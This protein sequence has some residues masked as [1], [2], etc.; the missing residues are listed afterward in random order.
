M[1]HTRVCRNNRAYIV[2]TAA[3]LS[4]ACSESYRSTVV[5]NP[6][7][8]VEAALVVSDSAPAV[9][10]TLVVS[11]QAIA[12]QGT[13]GSYTARINFDPAALQFDGEVP[14]TDKAIRA[15]N[16]LPGLVRIAGAAAA[17]FADG[18]LA[19]YRFVVLR[20]NSVRTL[21][22]V[23][24]EIHMISRVDAKTTLTIAPNRVTS[25]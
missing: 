9:G 7:P 6:V 4:A 1:T 20:A 22:L 10:R 2:A 18:Q 19:S 25:Q 5:Q 12:K 15:S 23:I 13:V 14:M 24:D 16:S 21:A 3:L 17:G 11:V 8:A